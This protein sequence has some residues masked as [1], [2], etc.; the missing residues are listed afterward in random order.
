MYCMACI[1]WP[2][3]PK[4]AAA[5]AAAATFLPVKCCPCPPDSQADELLVTLAQGSS[6]GLLADLHCTL[7]R[8]IQADMGAPFDEP[9]ISGRLMDGMGSSFSLHCIGLLLPCRP[10][11][12]ALPRLPASACC[13]AALP[14]CT[15][16]SA[17]RAHNSCCCPAARSFEH[18]LAA[19]LTFLPN[20]LPVFYS[21]RRGG[22][23]HAVR[24]LRHHAAG[25]THRQP[26][27]LCRAHAGGGVGLV[28][29]VAQAW[30][31]CG[32]EGRCA[33]P[34][35]ASTRQSPPPSSL[36]ASTAQCPSATKA[37]AALTLRVLHLTSHLPTSA[38]GLRH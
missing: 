29:R 1:G 22:S 6:S 26:L 20:F 17:A 13:P 16:R 31:S 28:R 37:A 36:R 8:L 3:R 24:P 18:C 21:I 25:A 27:L 33:L 19:Q 10:S 7:L 4:A 15:A 38:Q 12:L 11:A 5:A 23:R 9:S 35:T 30:P 2:T 34:S 14:L 32:F